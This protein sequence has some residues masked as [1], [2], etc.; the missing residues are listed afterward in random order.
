MSE[1]QNT[2]AVACSLD[3]KTLCLSSCGKSAHK[4]KKLLKST[5]CLTPRRAPGGLR[6]LID[7][8]LSQL[9]IVYSV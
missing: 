5:V 6:E 2:A 9:N 8:S 3:L 4:I 7:S 1:K